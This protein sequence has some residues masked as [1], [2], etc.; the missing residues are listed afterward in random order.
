MEPLQ[1]LWF[2]PYILL[3]F[4]SSC[5][6]GA[7]GEGSDASTDAD[8][9]A[10]GDGDADTDADADADTDTD[11]CTVN[12][13]CSGGECVGGTSYCAGTQCSDCP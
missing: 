6:G 10:D 11:A 8:S 4:A 7:D 13:I 5:S 3:A 2:A 9:G 12:T 1:K